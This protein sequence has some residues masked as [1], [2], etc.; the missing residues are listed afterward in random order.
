M[1][2]RALLADHGP[3]IGFGFV[4]ALLSSFGQT[5]FISLSAPESA[6]FR[7]VARS[8]ARFIPCHPWLP[9]LMIWVGGATRPGERPPLRR[10]GALSG[11]VRGGASACLWRPTGVSSASRSFALAPMRARHAQPYGG[12]EHGPAAGR[13]ARPGGRDRERLAFPAGESFLPG[14]GLALIA[15]IGWARCGSS[16]PDSSPCASPL[17]ALRDANRQG[18]GSH[19]SPAR[20]HAPPSE[21]APRRRDLLRDRRFLASC[22]PSWRRPRS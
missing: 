2:L 7:A 4:L 22:R 6:H 16:Q 19:A 1:K 13:H 15:L 11:L 18:A 21:A 17:S 20:R 5:T 3:I 9:D 12:D 8:S 10:R 14:V